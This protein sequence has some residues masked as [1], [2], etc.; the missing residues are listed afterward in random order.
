MLAQ[1]IDKLDLAQFLILG[2]GDQKK[3]V[4]EDLFEAIL[5]TVALDCNWDLDT[6]DEVVSVMLC[7][8]LLDS[9]DE[10]NHVAWIQ[11]WTTKH[12]HR[13]PEFHYEKGN[14]TSTWYYQLPKTGL[15]RIFVT[16]NTLVRFSFVPCSSLIVWT[17]FISNTLDIFLQT[18][19]FSSAI[20]VQNASSQT[21]AY[22]RIISFHPAVWSDSSILQASISISSIF[23]SCCLYVV[24]FQYRLAV[25]L[26]FFTVASLMSLSFKLPLAIIS[27]KVFFFASGDIMKTKRNK[28]TTH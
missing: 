13:V 7:P 19:I 21:S 10:E 15:S 20:F 26:S 8:E 18:S 28:Y 2:K 12:S 5:G 3:H 24:S 11:D 23:F 1:R 4:Q 9:K 22:G 6:L 17:A 25:W 14:Y 27:L 16:T